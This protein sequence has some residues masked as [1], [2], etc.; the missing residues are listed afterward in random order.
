MDIKLSAE[1]KC[2][3]SRASRRYDCIHGFAESSNFKY[4]DVLIGSF[5]SIKAIINLLVSFKEYL[6]Y[7][8]LSFKKINRLK[9]K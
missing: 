7:L 6:L 3:L 5:A 8:K 9:S 4:V 1:L 2:P